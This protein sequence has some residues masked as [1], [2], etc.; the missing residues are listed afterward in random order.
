M[1]ILAILRA[2]LRGRYDVER[3]VGHG[4]MAFVYA[5]R[6]LRLGRP[7]AIKVLRPE[8]TE[9]VGADRFLQEI[10]IEARLQHPHILALYESGQADGLLYYVMPYVEGESLRNRLER[11]PQLPIDDALHIARQVADALDHAHSHG[12]VHRD[13]KPATS[14]RR[15]SFY[16]VSTPWWLTS[17]SRAR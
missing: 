11:E 1:D 15:T 4:G 8:L 13:I 9:T 12:V 17:A 3:E 16:L 10:E 7:V 6:D 14:S 5:A 2:A